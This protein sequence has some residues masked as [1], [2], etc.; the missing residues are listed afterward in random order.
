MASYPDG[1]VFALTVFANWGSV[2]ELRNVF[3]Y[4]LK[5]GGDLPFADI[6]TDMGEIAEEFA[7]LASVL[8]PTTQ[9]WYGYSVG[10]LDGNEVSGLVSFGTAIP[11]LVAGDNEPTSVAGLVSFPTGFSRRICKKF[12]GVLADTMI[13]ASGNMSTAGEDALEDIGQWGIQL[14]EQSSGAWRYGTHV[15]SVLPFVDVQGYLVRSI[16]SPLS[17]RKRG[18]GI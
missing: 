11:G 9:S 15:P 17:R 4:Q 5:A 18:T 6:V 8:N 10:T 1:S 14:F 2:V 12:I 13:G 3:Q 7:D 16:P